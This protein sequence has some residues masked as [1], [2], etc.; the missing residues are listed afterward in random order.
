MYCLGSLRAGFSRPS[1]IDKIYIQM[2]KYFLTNVRLHDSLARMPKDAYRQPLEALQSE[3]EDLLAERA[4]IDRR[5]VKVRQAIV[6]LAHLSGDDRITN[7]LSR[8]SQE[9]VERAFLEPKL[10]LVDALRW[11]LKVAEKPLTPI[12][13]KAELD[14]LGYDIDKPNLLSSIHITLN[15]LVKSGEAKEVKEEEKKA[16]I[17]SKIEEIRERTPRRVGRKVKRE[18]KKE[19]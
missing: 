10:R 7:R 3:L 16:F 14:K 6:S 4:D 18:G 2:Y 8:L 9:E 1:W 12:D 15:R 17:W 19:K 11:I 13:V 5:I